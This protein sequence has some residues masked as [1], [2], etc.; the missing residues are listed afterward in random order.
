MIDPS[1]LSPIALGAMA[2]TALAAGLAMA[3]VLIAGNTPL[4]RRLLRLENNHRR[5]LS[6]ATIAE[7]ETAVIG[8]SRLPRL[9]RL[10]ERLKLMS[11][12]QLES[13]SLKLLH[14][15]IRAREGVSVFAV[16]K[17]AGT[18]LGGL[19]GFGL[20][21]LPTFAGHGMASLVTFMLGGALAGSMLPD[22]W[23]GYLGGRRR[24]QLRRALPDALDLLVIGAESGMALDQSL[25]RVAREL[26]VSWPVLAEELAM[27]RIE[28]TFL[29]SRR[30]ALLNFSLRVDVPQARGVVT[31]ML[32]SDRY[33]T[34]LADSLRVLSAEFRKERL[35]LAETKAARL[36][37]IMTV[38]LILFI[39][40]TLMIV[41]LGPAAI[42]ARKAL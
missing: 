31:T 7:P 12:S 29:P 30:D 27:L 9:A 15:G 28:M 19:A 32:Q 18:V 8:Q 26:M 42:M 11:A 25:D 1:Q 13:T 23:I 40:P 22:A 21:G 20:A 14:A 37:A 2:A 3:A 41:L 6:A 10:V 24:T 4:E 36:P 38:P 34:S 33:G 35:L 17:L 39:L 16:V 5:L